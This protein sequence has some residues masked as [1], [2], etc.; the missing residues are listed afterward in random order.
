MAVL[1]ALSL[2]CPPLVP[3]PFSKSTSEVCRGAARRGEKGEQIRNRPQESPNEL[4]RLLYIYSP[5]PP[6]HQHPHQAPSPAPSWPLQGQ[7]K[8]V[9]TRRKKFLA[10]DSS[11]G[12]SK[13]L[14]DG[15]A[16]G[17]LSLQAALAL[18]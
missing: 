3:K 17:E 18:S 7:Q 15:A 2:D 14:V 8:Q 4:K 10:E 16:L 9:E 11:H 1:E 6:Q 13:P 12:K 5:D